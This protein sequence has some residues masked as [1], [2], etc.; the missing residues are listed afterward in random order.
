MR[1]LAI[2]DSDSYLKWGAA[3]LDRLPDG[4]ERELVLIATP[5]LPSAA[6]QRAALAGTRFER[7]GVAVVEFAE[8]KRRIHDEQPDVVFLTVRGPVV[9][10]MSRLVGAA[11]PVKRPVIVSGLPGISIPETYLAL[12]YRSQADLLVLHSKQEVRAFSALA[13]SR[14]MRQRF[15]LATLPFLPSRKAGA[16]QGDEIVF[17]AQAK[18]PVTIE[19]RRALLADLIAV[20]RARPDRTVVLKLRGLAGEPQ[21]HAEKFPFDT[22]L[23]DV[24]D[25]PANVV[26]STASMG[27]HLERAAVLA[28]VSSTAAIES[29]AMGVPTVLLDDWGVSGGLINLVF[30]GSGL[31]GHTA[32]L[33]RDEFPPPTE[34][35]LHDNYLHEAVD[36]D[37]IAQIEQLVAQ[38]DRGELPLRPQHHG[39]FG[40]ALRRTW[41]RKLALGHWDHSVSGYLAAAVVIP[42]RGGVRRYRKV[43]ARMARRREALA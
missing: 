18:V 34:D 21:T 2:A 26:V 17:A 31:F 38:R 33:V 36:V 42:L 41:D 9:R 7:D 20:A 25:V 5:V 24:E 30:E 8:L 15:A 39:T 22:L 29:I 28:T 14:G 27:E 37:W 40:G 10:V 13:A 23:G 11:H 12:Y 1:V 19:E 6:Q 16:G 32:S 3:M 43:R 35:W 4:W